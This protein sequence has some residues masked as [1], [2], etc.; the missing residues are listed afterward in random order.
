MNEALKGMNSFWVEHMAQHRAQASASVSSG[1]GRISCHVE[2]P[3]GWK[4]TRNTKEKAFVTANDIVAAG[5]HSVEQNRFCLWWGEKKP[6]GNNTMTGYYKQGSGAWHTVKDRTALELQ[7]RVCS[8]LVN[9]ISLGLVFLIYLFLLFTT[10][11]S[12]CEVLTNEIAIF[13]ERG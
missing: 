6:T 8:Y 5:E 1:G 7:H 4:T 9:S 2:A 12:S 10:A 13:P 3:N 11:L